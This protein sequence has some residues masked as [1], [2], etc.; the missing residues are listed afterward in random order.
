MTDLNAHTVLRPLALPHHPDG[1]W[2]AT[3][4]CPD[5]D[6]K[7]GLQPAGPGLFKTC[8]TCNGTRQGGPPAGRV[9]DDHPPSRYG[10]GQ[11]VHLT[12]EQATTL[13][14]DGSIA[15]AGAEDVEVRLV[16]AAADR[17]GLEVVARQP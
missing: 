14:E 1:Y 16:R 12:A 17:L 8:G 13:V 2:D 9:R 3:D 11:T 6:P 15:S 7:T 5:C 4:P 10:P